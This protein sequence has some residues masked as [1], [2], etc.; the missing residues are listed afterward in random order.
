M[1]HNIPGAWPV[2]IVCIKVLDGNCATVKC[3]LS[4]DRLGCWMWRA[5][6]TI[7]PRGC[8]NVDPPGQR[9]SYPHWAGSCTY[10]HSSGICGW[11]GKKQTVSVSSLQPR[12]FK[13]TLE[14]MFVPWN[15]MQASEGK[16]C[17]F[18]AAQYANKGELVLCCSADVKGENTTL[19]SEAFNPKAGQTLQTSEHSYTVW[20]T[21]T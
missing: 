6:A 9:A 15:M 10:T 1:N 12:H 4:S 21:N 14:M 17:S 8:A 16:G 2:L 13:E 5:G 7:G 19:H 3:S 18:V 20:Q 11:Q